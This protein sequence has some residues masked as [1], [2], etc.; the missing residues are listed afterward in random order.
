MAPVSTLRIVDFPEPVD[1]ASG[2]FALTNDDAT[3]IFAYIAWGAEPTSD[4]ETDASTGGFWTSGE[5][6]DLGASNTIYGAGDAT[7]ETGYGFCTGDG[8]T[9]PDDDGDAG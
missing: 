6:V 2:E 4:L 1:A 3:F 5:F 9:L 7:T 8:D